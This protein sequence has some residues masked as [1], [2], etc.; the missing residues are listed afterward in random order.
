MKSLKVRK[1]QK[2]EITIIDDKEEKKVTIDDLFDN[3][4]SKTSPKKDDDDDKAKKM[5]VRRSNLRAMTKRS[6][7]TISLGIYQK[8]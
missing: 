5:R 3:E 7:W 4:P 1:S 8:R 2:I 6:Q